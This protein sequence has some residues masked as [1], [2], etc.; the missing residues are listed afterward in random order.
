MAN[1]VWKRYS[2]TTESAFFPIFQQVIRQSDGKDAIIVGVLNK[3]R[4][5]KLKGLEC[6]DH[7]RITFEWQDQDICGI[8]IFKKVEVE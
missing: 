4:T 1:E 6:R 2:L 5:D 7:Y 3:E 8:D